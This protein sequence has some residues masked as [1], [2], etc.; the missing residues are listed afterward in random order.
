MRRVTSVLSL[1]M[2]VAGVLGGCD[3][4]SGGD[5]RGNGNPPP[6]LDSYV[7]TT[8]PFVG[9]AD[10]ASGTYSA[11][12]IGSY[13]GKKQAL[14]GS[15]DFTTGANLGQLAG[16]EI[17]K[18]STGGIYAVD[19]TS[20]G[21]PVPQQVSSETA[22][23]IDDPCTLS[24][25]VVPGA[26]YDY[27]GVAFTADLVNP[28]N[29]SYI[30]RLPGPD[31]VCDTPDDVIHMVKTGMAPTDAPVVASAMPVATVRTAQGGISGFVI[32]SGADLVLVDGNF[33]NPVVLG[34]FSAPIGVAAALPVGTTEGYP[35]GQFYVVDGNIVYVNYASPS[36]S[37]PL[38][39]IP[40]WTPTNAAASFAASPTSLYFSINTAASGTTPESANIYA[41]PADGSAPPAVI[42]TEAGRVNSLVV[43]VLGTNLVVGLVDPTYTIKALPTA[44]GA[45][46]TL[47][48]SAV[49]DGSFIATAT[50]VY[51]ETWQQSIDVA[52]KTVT[53]TGTTSGIVAVNG[54]IV[55]APLADSTFV[56]GGEQ[57]PWPDDTVTTATAYKTVFQVQNLSP[58]TVT[59]SVTGFT[60]T[61]DGVSGGTLVAID[62]TS[63]QAGATLG[64]LPSSTAVTLGGTF[65]D[66]AG[67]GFL[68][69][70][71]PLS[72]QDPATEDLYVLNSQTANSL[73]LITGNL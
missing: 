5:Y 33:A 22:A 8:G 35:T 16:I 6:V 66:G 64:T 25:T 61:E 67:T 3:G 60:Y 44:G 37:A 12:P 15:I 73:T 4:G 20:I 62:T 41:L 43:P 49:N 69:A 23:T 71:N 50:T 24:G 11:A 48:T 70:S 9:W 1:S 40:N 27:V 58:V 2:V 28:T 34:T 54:T 26:N 32:K 72:T 21:A 59:D 47:L 56:N 18:S 45:A 53:R 17:Y 36:V 19:L 55:A 14:R 39:T 52:A 30:Y 10:D 31:G 7:G 68:Q 29:S 13:A 63:N 57:L 42:D 65:R 46:T 51:Y 38:F